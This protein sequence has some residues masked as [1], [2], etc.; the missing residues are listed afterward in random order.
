MPA[1]WTR[2]EPYILRIDGDDI[3]LRFNR[4]DPV[5]F[6]IFDAQ[7][8]AFTDDRRP[9][10]E[11]TSPPVTLSAAELQHLRANDAWVRQTFAERISVVEGDLVVD[12][13]VVTDG[14][15]LYKLIGTIPGACAD[16]L[17]NF[18][19]EHVLTDAEKKTWRSR[20]AS[21]TTS[22]APS[23]GANGGIPV[24]VAAVVANADSALSADATVPS[25]ALS[26]TAAPAEM[27]SSFANVP[28][29]S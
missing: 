2:Q 28:C 6:A 10:R 1:Q 9:P 8:K 3:R 11:D 17:S 7:F 14:L 29:G 21:S 15:E 25:P 24:P 22:D 12:G 5:D 27:S 20:F 16:V 26:G 18:Y 4:M 19:L 23:P 13:E